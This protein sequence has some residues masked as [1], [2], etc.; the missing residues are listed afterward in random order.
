MLEK[1][2]KVAG[3]KIIAGIDEAGRG[4]LA[5]PVVAAAVILNKIDSFY[6]PD[7]KDSKK[8]NKITREKIFQKLLSDLNN[9]IGIGI[10]SSKII[11]K[12][13]IRQA[14]FLA[15]RRAIFY[16]GLLPDFLFVDGFKIPFVNIK[17][18]GI[19]KGE[20][21][22]ISIAAASVIAKVYRDQLMKKY[23]NL[24]GFDK[25]FFDVNSGYGTKKHT[26]AIV[27]FGHCP[28]HRITFNKVLPNNDCDKLF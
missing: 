23:H 2:K 10:V 24:S 1:E 13:N 18:I 5:G 15:M 20:D 19:V 3:Y 16:L 17:Q 25:Y 6:I 12:I 7:L 26:E 22:S 27:K 8:L 4:A 14:S 28:I 11:D 9:I 21:K